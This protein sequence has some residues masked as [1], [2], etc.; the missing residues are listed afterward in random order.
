M[1]GIRLV[2][3]SMQRQTPHTLNALQKLVM[4]MGAVSK[5]AGKKTVFGR[6]KGQ[7]AYS[8]FLQMLR[9]TIHAMVLDGLVQ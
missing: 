4:A 6:D 1:A 2:E 9:A 3:E 5:N 7:E 8:H